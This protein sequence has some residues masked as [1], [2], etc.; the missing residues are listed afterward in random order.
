MAIAAAYETRDPPDDIGLRE[1]H[2]SVLKPT[3]SY[4]FSAPKWILVAD[5]RVIG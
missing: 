2:M 3:G 4:T 5:A 1:E